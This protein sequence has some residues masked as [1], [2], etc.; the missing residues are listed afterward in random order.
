MLSATVGATGEQRDDSLGG[1]HTG[2]S[3][4]RV[5]IVTD[6]IRRELSASSLSPP[7]ARVLA[8]GEGDRQSP[9]AFPFA[10]LPAEEMDSALP[11]AT[12]ARLPARLAPPGGELAAFLP[13]EL[14]PM[15]PPMA[16]SPP[17]LDAALLTRVE[18]TDVA[19]P[20]PPL[21][22]PIP[23]SSAAADPPTAVDGFGSLAASLLLPPGWTPPQPPPPPR[24]TAPPPPRR[25]APVGLGGASADESVPST[26][27]RDCDPSYALLLSE[28]AS[29]HAAPVAARAASFVASFVHTP[30]PAGADASAHPD[31]VAVRAALASLMSMARTLRVTYAAYGA[32]AVRTGL[33]RFLL[34][35]L[36][37]VAMGVGT[38]AVEDKVLQA[39][40][41]TLSF[42]HARHIGVGDELTAGP[43]WRAAQASLLLMG[44]YSYPDDKMACAA[45]C[46][47]HLSALLQETDAAFVRL[48]ALCMLHCRPPQLHS[49]LEYAARFV[50]PER[51]WCA[52]LG[53]PLAMARA[54][55]QWLAIQDPAAISSE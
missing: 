8:E 4:P 48:L 49:Q 38:D 20:P 28:L 10:R 24:L 5:G 1:A 42:M 14:P 15:A 31:A 16:P 40:L 11:A 32:G 36:H 13:V 27:P 46:H 52:E 29:P 18:S 43:R 12:T 2:S 30:P 23:P 7:R 41:G 22:A 51:M 34:S 17:L 50:N 47:A 25:H 39:Q 55:M 53:M 9:P 35:Q 3:P 45:A 6:A 44:A 19:M 54:A 37:S 26:T 21:E 33:E